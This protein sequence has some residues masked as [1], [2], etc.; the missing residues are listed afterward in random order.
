MLKCEN[1][2]SSYGIQG[3]LRV[4][5]VVLF[6]ASYHRGTQLWWN[7]MVS[8]E[9]A[10]HVREQCTSYQSTKACV[11]VNCIRCGR[12]DWLLAQPHWYR[13]ASVQFS[14][15]G[16]VPSSKCSAEVLDGQLVSAVLRSSI[17]W[18]CTLACMSCSCRLIT[19]RSVTLARA[20][21]RM[22][23]LF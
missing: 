6:Q 18:D 9:T 7:Y 23:R 17:G 11:A 10:S 1:D 8:L 13:H 19:A 21:T 2:G 12:V 22:R 4:L 14:W 5:S 20:S 3:A 15:Q 16:P